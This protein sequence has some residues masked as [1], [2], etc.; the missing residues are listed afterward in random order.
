MHSLKLSYP[1]KTLHWIV[2]FELLIV[3]QARKEQMLKI[4]DFKK[5]RA[6]DIKSQEQEK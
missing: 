5:H 4:D 3:G 6:Y 2:Y 1:Q